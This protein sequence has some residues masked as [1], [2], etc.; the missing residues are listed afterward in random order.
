MQCA[1]V[2]QTRLTFLTSTPAHV[3]LVSARGVDVLYVDLAGKAPDLPS[4]EGDLSG[5]MPSGDV[6]VTAPDVQV[7]GGDASLTAG[8]AAGAVAAVGAI[9]A[10]A[11][12]LSGEGGDVDAEVSVVAYFRCHR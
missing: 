8:L 1:I 11:I 2:E 7:E 12:G 6:E 3:V 10:A 4:V 5:A 9:G